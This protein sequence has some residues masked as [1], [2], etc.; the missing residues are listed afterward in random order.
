MFAD[1]RLQLL[2]TD[3][4]PK[5]NI[6]QSVGHVPLVTYRQVSSGTPG[7]SHHFNG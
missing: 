1:L 2:D 3:P 5:E 4:S 7:N 6:S